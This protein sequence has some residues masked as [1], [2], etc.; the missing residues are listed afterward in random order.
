VLCSHTT[1]KEPGNAPLTGVT[2]LAAVSEAAMAYFDGREGLEGLPRTVLYNGAD[3]QRC[4][5][6]RGRRAI[7]AAWGLKDRDVVIGYLGRQSEEKNPMAPALAVGVSPDSYH[8]IYYGAGPAGNG[9]CPSTTA[10][11][12]A[13]I[14]R[15]FQMHQPVAEVGDVLRGF[16]VLMLASRREAFSLALIEAWLVGVPVVATPVGSI[17]ELERKF[18]PLTVPV[19]LD[20]SPE[21]LRCA[22]EQ[23]IHSSRRAQLVARA[24]RIA[25][26]HFTVR[27]MADRW[28]GYLANVVTGTVK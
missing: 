21:D 25:G 20:A 3:P 19:P 13:A 27:A 18:G 28:M 8:A 16:D 10:W 4:K 5:Q 24:R 22:V 9:F 7:R 1:L 14:P 26:K 6:Q 11:C 2:H 15:H 23:A 12:E 17:P